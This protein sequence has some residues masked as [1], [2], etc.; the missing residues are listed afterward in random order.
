MQ[1]SSTGNFCGE[2]L[3]TKQAAREF[4]NGI[5]RSLRA[6][7]AVHDLH[8]LA[9]MDSRADGFSLVEVMVATCVLAV[10][11]VS[12]VQLSLVAQAAN[13]SAALV[14]VAAMLA[15]DKM[16]Q[17][18]GLS[19]P[20]LGDGCCEYFDVHGAPL[21]GGAGLPVATAFVRR[22][23]IASVSAFPE[24]ARVLHVSVAPATGTSPVRLVSIRARRLG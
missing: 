23:A 14:T 9:V 20:D 18:R 8:L 4:S 6:S 21:Q 24:S 10:G 7:A 13:R 16:E 2:R 1:R 15:Q 11:V 12:L 17:L 22:W 19:W 5:Q 3:A